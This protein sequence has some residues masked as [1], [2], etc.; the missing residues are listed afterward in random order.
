M[1]EAGIIRPRNNPF[2]SPVPLVKKKD[3]SWQ[4]CVEYKALNSAMIPNRFPIPN[5]DELLDELHRAI[6]F[7]KLGLK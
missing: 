3:G 4:F 7:T 2:F 6:A 5:I 1:R